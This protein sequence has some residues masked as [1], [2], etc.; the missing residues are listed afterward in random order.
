MS[1]VECGDVILDTPLGEGER[2]PRVSIVSRGVGGRA[3]FSCA[4][5]WA[6]RGTPETVC[7]PHA[8]W[9]KPFPVC[10]GM[11]VDY[12]NIIQFPY[13]SFQ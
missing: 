1:G 13:H 11:C 7:L 12:I 3:A 9:A 8:H 2:P 5:G 6:L 4:P 10:K